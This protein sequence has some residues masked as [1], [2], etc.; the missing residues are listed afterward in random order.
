MNS[1][2]A[3]LFLST[4]ACAQEVRYL[5]FDTPRLNKD[6]APYPSQ[7]PGEGRGF[8]DLD[9]VDAVEGASLRMRID[10]GIMQAQF[11]AHNANGTRGFAH[12]YAE[13]SPWVWDTYNRMELWIKAPRNGPPITPGRH[14]YQIGTYVKTFNPPV[15]YADEENNHWYHHVAVPPNGHWTKVVLNAHPHHFRGGNGNIEWGVRTYTQGEAGRNYFDGLTRWYIHEVTTP[16]SAPRTFHLDR[17]R[18]WR[19]D[20][21]AAQAADSLLYSL[22]ASY[23]DGRLTFTASALKSAAPAWHE[24]RWARQDIRAIGGWDAATPA[25]AGRVRPGDRG[26]NGMV[27]QTDSLRLAP[28]DTVWLAI[29]PEGSPLYAQM[30]LPILDSLGRGAAIVTPPPPPDTVV[31]LPPPPPPLC[32]PDTVTV[33]RLDTVRFYRTDTLRLTVRDT[34]LRVDTILT[35]PRSFRILAEP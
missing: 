29:K 6:G 13:G 3:V 22:T 4:L 28:G 1:L 34:L 31:V 7:Y 21:A 25:P 9:N 32:R 26:Y 20:H 10:T 18:F 17:A 5:G 12:E 23:G 14:Q 27:Y 30:S 24:V 15:P 11:N 33:V 16:A 2:L 19:E 35:V 8:Y